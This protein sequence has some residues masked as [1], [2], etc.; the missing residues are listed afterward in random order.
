M[1]AALLNLALA[2]SFVLFVVSLGLGL[3]CR[4]SFWPL[5]FRSVLVLLVSSITLIVFF[6]FF[7]VVL[8]QFLAKRVME[9]RRAAEEALNE[10]DR[11]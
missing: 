2:L 11:S 9:H 1:S 5:L 7:N 3:V 6:R 10:E 8:A 4:V